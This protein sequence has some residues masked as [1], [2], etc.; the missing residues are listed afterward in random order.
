MSSPTSV[1]LYGTLC[2]LP[3]LA[4]VLGRAP[5]GVRARLPDHRVTCVAGATFPALC[6]A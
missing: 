2:H 5:D 3:L 4:I 1:F 6:E